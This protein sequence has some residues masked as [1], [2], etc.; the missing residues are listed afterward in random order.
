MAGGSPPRGGF[1]RSAF[2]VAS[3]VGLEGIQRQETGGG[4]SG[5][6]D[7]PAADWFDE[8][9]IPGTGRVGVPLSSASLEGGR[10]GPV[11]F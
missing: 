2:Y 6:F 7:P 11:A 9:S 4:I 10:I 3:G 1:F 8:T 5:S